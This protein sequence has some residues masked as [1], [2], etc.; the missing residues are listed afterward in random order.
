M[1]QLAFS[2]FSIIRACSTADLAYLLNPE[3]WKSEAENTKERGLLDAVFSWSISDVLNN[4]L[5]RTKVRE[6]PKTFLSTDDYLK[7]FIFPLLEETRADLLSNMS[8]LSSTPVREVFNVKKAKDDYKPPKDLFYEIHLKE[9]RENDNIETLY[10]PQVGDLVALTNRR[11]KCIDDLNTPKRPYLVALVGAT[12]ENSDIVLVLAANHIVFEKEKEKEEEKREREVGPNC[13]QCSSQVIESAVVSKSREVIHSFNLDDSQEAAVLGVI[14]TRECHHQSTVKLLWG[15]PGTGKTKTVGSL[16]FALLNMKC[17]TLTCAPTNVAVVGVASRLLSFVMDNLQHHTYGLGDIVLF[18]NGKRMKLDDRDGLSDVFLDYRVTILAKCFAPLTGWKS[19][20]E[21]MICLLDDPEEQYRLYL[22]KE[23][24][25]EDED[26]DSENEDD[27]LESIFGSMSLSEKHD[28]EEEMNGK[29]RKIFGSMS[30]SEKH[31]KEEEINGQK[32]KNWNLMIT[33]TL[34]EKKEKRKSKNEDHGHDILT[35]EEFFMKTFNLIGKRLMLYIPSLY[36]HLPTCFVSLEVAK[37]MIKVVGLLQTLGT[38]F[39]NFVYANQGLRL[40]LNA[41]T[42]SVARLVCLQLLKNLRGTFSLPNCSNI[43]SLCLTNACLIFC[44]ASSSAKLHTEGPTPIE[45]LVIDEAAQLKEC[46]SAI[47]LQLP[48]LCHAILVGDERQLPAMVQSKAQVFAIKEKLGNLYSADPDCDFSVNVSSVDGFQGSEEDVIIIS[49]V[50]SNGNGSIGFLS[51]LQRTNVGLTR[52]RYCLWVLGNEATLVNSRSVWKKL[53]IDAKDR[54]CFYNANEDKNLDKAI[55]GALLELGQ[56]DTLFNMDSLL[57]KEAKWKV[58]FSD[59]FLKSMTRIKDL[60]IRKEVLTLLTKLSSGW[61]CAQK[62]KIVNG[63]T[64]T[65]S[66][67]ME[68]Y[69]ANGEF[70]LIWTVDIL[71]ENSKYIQVLK[72]WDILP[73]SKIPQLANNLNTLFGNYTVDFMN[74]CIS[75]QFEGSLVVPMTWPVDSNA[76]S[77]SNRAHSDPSQSLASQLAALNLKTEHGTRDGHS[78]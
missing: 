71:T 56:I 65:C 61:R 20:L 2:H 30:L 45:L 21:T 29:K 5:Y 34:K 57:F 19:S 33:K 8:V 27:V 35:F 48:G 58:C 13:A 73:T 1:E 70:N 42:V 39:R 23:G 10:A 16:L 67:L 53:V 41:I 72:V 31:D 37:S 28:K 38:T 63:V 60:N 24:K 54:G 76:F 43:R 66:M 25:K 11:P 15:P 64:G 4:N 17:R 75:K 44:T 32:R 69:N 22:N 7:S 55:K 68:Q 36:T 9:V 6:I 12:D 62:D 40:K 51:N 26:T 46:E 50:R 14:A 18:G 47:P 52:A 59:E 3:R 74:R 78:R 77:K 49:T